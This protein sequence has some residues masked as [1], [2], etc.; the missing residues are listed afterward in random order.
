MSCNDK[1]FSLRLK[2]KNILFMWILY[3]V[4]KSG[5]TFA[6]KIPCQ[7][8]KFIILLINFSLS[9]FLNWV[10][11]FFNLTAFESSEYSTEL[12]NNNQVQIKLLVDCKLTVISLFFFHG[13]AGGCYGSL[14]CRGKKPE[15]FILCI[16]VC[17]HV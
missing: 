4:E 10:N 2:C 5:S 3:K 14:F 16:F 15:L 7:Q 11:K 9:K 6:N 1:E 8:E 12:Q 13:D 17:R